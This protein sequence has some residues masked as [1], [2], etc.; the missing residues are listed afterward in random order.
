MNNL[1]NKAIKQLSKDIKLKSLIDKNEKPF[2]E[3]NNNYYHTLSKSII[4]QQLSGKVA[5]IIYN[6]F[7]DLFNNKQPKAN[8]FI[9]IDDSKLKEIG[10]SRQKIS[11]LKD[12]SDYFLNK[13]KSIDFKSLSEQEI[14][15]ELIKIKGIG[16]WT[17]DMFLMFTVLKSNILPV[18]DLGIKKAFKELYNLDDLPT[19]N[20]MI[21]KSKKW[22]PYRTIACC[23]LWTIVDDGD[24][25]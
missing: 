20:F 22:E 25:W 10:L 23:Y 9:N 3:E 2:F 7:L 16:H 21:E 17:I 12:L 15:D 11:Y 5:K 4:Y 8:I 24:V 19:D 1:I 14:R 13:G 6:R 18:G